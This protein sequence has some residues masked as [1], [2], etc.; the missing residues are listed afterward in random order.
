MQG[1]L[2]LI[3]ASHTLPMWEAHVHTHKKTP[4]TIEAGISPRFS[5]VVP[6][7]GIHDLLEVLSQGHEDRNM[8]I[9]LELVYFGCKGKMKMSEESILKQHK[10]V[11][12]YSASVQFP[13]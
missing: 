1:E 9:C 2:Q 3:A 12:F 5:Y 7:K 10:K 6:M 8:Q 4:L 11:F 13:L